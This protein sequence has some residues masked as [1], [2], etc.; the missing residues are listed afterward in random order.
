MNVVAR[1]RG[2]GVRSVVRARDMVSADWV[3]PQ[4]D[5]GQ[6]ASTG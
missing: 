4:G 5:P 3:S 6:R 2:R 1:R